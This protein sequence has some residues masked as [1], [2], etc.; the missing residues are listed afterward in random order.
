MSTENEKEATKWVEVS[1]FA[2]HWRIRIAGQRQSAKLS[3]QL[4]CTGAC[5]CRLR[6]E[7]SKGYVPIEVT[8]PKCRHTMGKHAYTVSFRLFKSTIFV[9]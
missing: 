7:I 1:L 4:R 3:L 5:S 9:G 8:A 2:V 6:E